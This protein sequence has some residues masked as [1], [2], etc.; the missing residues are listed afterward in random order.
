[1]SMYVSHCRPHHTPLK[2]TTS[3]LHIAINLGKK[4]QHPC[5]VRD[6]T[7]QGTQHAHI[8]IIYFSKEF[9][10]SLKV[11]TKSPIICNEDWSI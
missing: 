8:L 3:S 6:F 7:P 1:M 10:Q 11:L 2:R 9:D 5:Q 4:F